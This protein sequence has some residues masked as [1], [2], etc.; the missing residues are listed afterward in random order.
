MRPCAI[1]APIAV[2][3][4]RDFPHE[5]G[6]KAS[7]KL[8]AFAAGR[9]VLLLAPRP[10]GR[11]GTTAAQAQQRAKAVTQVVLGIFSYARWPVEPPN[12]VCAWSAPPSTPMT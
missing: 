2:R 7:D 10:A 5:R 6:R 12:C 3:T 1:V 4:L 11:L 9:P 8:C